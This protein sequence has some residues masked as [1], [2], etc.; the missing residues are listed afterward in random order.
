MRRTHDAREN[1]CWHHRNWLYRS[2]PHRGG[3]AIGQHRVH[4]FGGIGLEIAERDVIVDDFVL[5]PG[6]GQINEPTLA[7]IRLAAESEA[8]LLDPVY[9][10]RC[11]AGLVKFVEQGRI[12][13]GSEVLFIHTGGTPAIFA[14]QSDLSVS[15]N[16]GASAAV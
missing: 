11:M 9:S 12:P 1:P 7:A 8:L 3:Q 13:A 6:Y 10:G 16:E 4:R 2:R 5:A 15:A 14:Y